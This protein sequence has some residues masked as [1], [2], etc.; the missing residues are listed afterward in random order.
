MELNSIYDLHFQS[1]QCG[2][3]K[4]VLNYKVCFGEKEKC[5]QKGEEYPPPPSPYKTSF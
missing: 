5:A 3:K 1:Y 4:N 2:E